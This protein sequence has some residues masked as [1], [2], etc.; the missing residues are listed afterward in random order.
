MEIE[1]VA[2]V[3]LA[4]RRPAEEQRELAVSRGLLRQIVI[5]DQG[6]AAFVAEV[7]ANGAARVGSDELERRRVRGR[8][9][10][11][12]GVVHGPV[13]GKGLDHLRH[14]GAFL[15]DGH[16]DAGDV[17]ALLVDD[18]VNGNGSLAGLAVADDKLALAAAD[19]DH[20]VNSLDA[21]LERLAHRLALH[22]ARRN[23]FDLAE[24][25][26]GDGALAVDGLADAVHHTADD[27]IAHGHLGDP[28]GPLHDVALADLGVVSHEH[29]AHVLLL[30]VERHAHDASRELQELAGHDVVE[31]EDLGNTV[32]DGDHGADFG[33]LNGLLE[34]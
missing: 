12:D 15:A 34:V 18:G 32:A 24:L 8:C 28:L 4:S 21:G 27:R 2:G 11:D 16:V 30:E 14:G 9:R 6:V 7:F 5:H 22:N 25:L 31:S 19:G 3:R 1:Y 33:D 23:H 20:G 26:R 13:F 10:H 29:R 17:L